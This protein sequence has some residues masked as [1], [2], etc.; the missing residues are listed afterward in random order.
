MFVRTVQ[1]PNDRLSIRIVENIKVNGKVKQKTVCGIGVFHKDEKEKIESFK[2][3]GDS[4]IAQIRQERAEQQALPGLEKEVF[5]PRKNKR[6]SQ[7][8]SVPVE[9]LEEES[10]VHTG[11]KDIFGHTYKQLGLFDSIGCGRNKKEYNEVLEEIILSRIESP[12][13][14]RKSVKD[15]ERKAQKEFHVNKVYRM[16]DYLYKSK[17]RVKEKIANNTLSLFNQKIDI[18]FFDVTTLYFESFIPDEL[19]VSGYSKDGKFKETQVMLALMVTSEGVPLEYKLFPGNTYEGNTL[20]ESL[21]SLRKSYDIRDALVVADRAMFTSSNL[22]KLEDRGIEFIVSAK[23]KTLKKSLK[24]SILEDVFAIKSK[25][26]YWVK[27]YEYNNSRLVVSYSEKR[28]KKSRIERERILEK[29]GKKERNGKID[30]SKLIKN[31]GEKKYIKLEDKSSNTAVINRDKI[32][33]EEK[34]DGV[35]GVMTNATK[36]KMPSDDVIG[37]YKGLW[38]I[39][40]AFRI[41]KHDLKMRPVYHWTPRRIE[42]HILLCFMAY[43]VVSTLRYKLKKEGLNLSVARIKEELSYVQSS[44]VKVIGTKKRFMMPSQLNEVQRK[45]YRALGIKYQSKAQ[46]MH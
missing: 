7:E 26:T 1:K 39:E 38:E 11:A 41:N 40:N 3:I 19:R 35:Y 9:K 2:R 29:L 15:I 28:A 33:F 25:C 24:E 32:I 27:E 13:S 31:S 20:I 36:E 43:S 45:I 21:D 46:I 4:M 34:W 14:K 8:S 44:V 12:V 6:K 23:L 16:M 5:S 17:E 30:V 18:A 37:A 22:E 42:A 10:R